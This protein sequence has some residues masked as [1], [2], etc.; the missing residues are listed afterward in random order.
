MVSLVFTANTSN[1]N[2]VLKHDYDFRFCDKRCLEL[3]S[4]L[5]LF[6]FKIRSWYQIKKN[7]SF[8]LLNIVFYSHLDLIESYYCKRSVSVKKGHFSK[9][10]CLPAH[11]VFR[12]CK[13]VDGNGFEYAMCIYIFCIHISSQSI[14]DLLFLSL[15]GDIV[16]YFQMWMKLT[17]AETQVH[18]QKHLQPISYPRERC[19]TYTFQIK[20]INGLLLNQTKKE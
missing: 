1:I 13:K 15:D 10:V 6:F 11:S 2:F 20:K 16:K 14:P 5:I 17:A 3:Y 18:K 19:N 7:A 8:Y 12:F 4:I 9:L